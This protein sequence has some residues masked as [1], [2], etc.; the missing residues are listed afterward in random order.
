MFARFCAA[1]HQLAPEKFLIVQ[2]LH[3]ALRFVDRLHLDERETFR[4]L[5]VTIAHNLRVLDVP[6]AVKELEQIA[7]GRIERQI[8]NVKTRRSD[9]DRLR[10][11]LRPRL[12]LLLLL[13]LL[14]T[15]TR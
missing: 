8:A 7:L 10:F 12:A 4:A 14:L 2:F 3:C 9:F 15:V 6:D 13:M 1:H 11:A 5:V